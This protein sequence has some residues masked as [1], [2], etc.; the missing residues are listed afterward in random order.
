MKLWKKIIAWNL[1]ASV[2]LFSCSKTD[3]IV[4]V[5]ENTS[6]AKYVTTQLVENK[7]FTED[8]KLI[9]KV[10]SS[11]QTSISPLASWIIQ[12]VNVQIWDKVKK[13]DILAS[14]DTRSNLTSINLN[15]AQNVYDNTVW[16]FY[17]NKEA[18][19]RGLDTAKL[20]YENA[21]NTKENIYKTTQKQLELAQAQL[22]AI[23]TQKQNTQ[24]TATSALLLA[25]ESL[26]NAE[27]NLNNFQEN[28]WETM[29]WFE[30]KRKT[31]VNN[32]RVALDSWNAVFA[33]SLNFV[34]TILS[35]TPLNEKS[36]TAYEIYLSAK[37]PTYKDQAEQLFRE[38]N[39][40]FST[41][42][43]SYNQNMSEEQLLSYYENVLI[44]NNKLVLLFDKM[45]AVLD[46]TITAT[47]LPES[48][49]AEMKSTIRTYQTQVI[50]TKSSLLGL[51][52]SLNDL[53]SNITSTTTSLN[54]QKA[55]LEQAITIAKAN[56]ENTKVSTTSSI[57]T[58]S[59]TENTTKLQLENTIESIKSSRDS[60][61]NAVK[62]A[63]NQYTAA[64]ANYES[65][66]ASTK[67]QLDTANGQKQS[68][69]QQM[70]NAFIK[71]PFDGIITE[72]N[73]DVW[74][75]VSQSVSAFWI[76]NTAEKIIKLDITSENAKYLSLG[77]QVKLEKNWHTS[78]WV[79]SVLSSGTNTDTNMFQAEITFQS[80]D[81]NSSIVLWDFIDIYI[82]KNLWWEVFISVPFS[83]ILVGS[84]DTYSVYI[85]WKNNTVEEKKVSI[86]SSN[87]TEVIITSWLNSWERIITSGALN[88]SVWDLV[89]Y[90][91]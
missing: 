39:G 2:L 43:T 18:L 13:W 56:L 57:D 10:A 76:A 74:Q 83:S 19:E 22:D 86:G 8:L 28:Y 14:I 4:P 67:S 61:D 31:L 36:N 79:I 65:S 81:F 52:N 6:S 90:E 7:P 44:L 16:I 62:I 35:I 59:S 47:S 17:A 66:L 38:A 32:I 55:S 48:S 77:K 11:Q 12:A 53:D 20:Q 64:Q 54:T 45:N 51:T 75:W 80:K 41:I 37:N 5:S 91:K 82:Q 40:Y 46:N 73:I 69:Q 60:A 26:K 27:L 72:K 63:L 68:L 21:V 87:S 50:S 24:K 1:L 34:D 49:L 3:E 85:V 84:S 70:D 25:E 78:T 23:G 33:S 9:W 29:K 71:A 30:T 89:E 58:I 88:V 42:K 15:N